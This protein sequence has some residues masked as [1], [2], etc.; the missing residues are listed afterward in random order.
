MHKLIIYICG[1]DQN[2][3]LI[4]K[5]LHEK[6]SLCTLCEPLYNTAF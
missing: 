2:V 1:I 5:N 4:H 6:Y 3:I